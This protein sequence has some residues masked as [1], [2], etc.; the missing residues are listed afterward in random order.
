MQ[1]AL[2]EGKSIVQNR[3]IEKI[4]DG[5]DGL[6]I[7]QEIEEKKMRKALH[8][9]I[10]QYQEVQ[11]NFEGW[12]NKLS[13]NMT[14]D[15]FGSKYSAT[16]IIASGQYS[17][18]KQFN[19]AIAQIRT[20]DE[21]REPS[22][23]NLINIWLCILQTFIITMA[24]GVTVPITKDYMSSCHSDGDLS[25][26]VLSLNSFT[27]VLISFI[28]SPWTNYQFKVPAALLSIVCVFSFLFYCFA[29]YYDNAVLIL[30][31]R[32]LLGIGSGK[33]LCRRYILQ[34][35]PRHL[36]RKY[37]LTYAAYTSF[38]SAAGPIACW[39]CSFIPEKTFFNGF[40]TF[41]HYTTP[42]W[43]AFLLISLYTISVFLYYTDPYKAGFYKYDDE[44]KGL[45]VDY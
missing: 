39:L 25:G 36:V 31:G 11:Q 8:S 42:G 28:L 43:L 14:A 23:M 34:F 17:K 21:V 15:K 38:G 4:T 30:V 12:K 35:S 2:K 18:E 29:G 33:V 3:S 16:H 27:Q 22:N 41:N 9:I 7:L 19:D 40:L 6:E 37:S 10:N 5:E 26:I 44:E 24:Y 45:R 32:L 20:E 13:S 1:K